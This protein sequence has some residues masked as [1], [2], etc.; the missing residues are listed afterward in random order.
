ME[1]LGGTSR[2]LARPIIVAGEPR[3]LDRRHLARQLRA[4][5]REAG[6]LAAGGQP[7]DDRGPRRQRLAA[8]RRRPATG[9]AHDRADRG[10]LGQRARPAVGRA[11]QPRRD[12]PPGRRPST[13]CSTGSSG[14]SATSGGSSTTPATSCG[15][16]SRSC[17]ASSSWRWPDRVTTT[18]SSPRSRARSTRPCA[19]A[20]WPTTSSCWPGRA[21]GE[22]ALHPRSVDLG[23]AASRV[24]RLLTEGAPVEV[25]G[26]GSGVGR[27]RPGGADPAQPGHQRQALRR[28]PGGR[29]R[30][31]ARRGRGAHR[32]RRR[33]RLPAVDACRSPSSGS[34][35][36][37]PRRG[38][39][40]GGTGLGLSIA[41]TLARS[42]GA[43]I[44]AGNGTPPEGAWVRLVFPGDRTDT[45]EPE[46]AEPRPDVATPSA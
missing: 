28:G 13:S 38:R 8:G 14:R 39:V 3:V 15:R 23:A 17:G 36:P 10:D 37:T 40:T 2:L 34:C 43:T 9:A 24:A 11:G 46:L 33:A 6:A 42:Q 35:A 31:R 12:R 20:G 45:D 30:A 7:A 41:A 21:S 29:H 4:H 5:P 44:E 1:A 19:W 18:R 25:A 16:R 26:V 32:G 22:L 27:P